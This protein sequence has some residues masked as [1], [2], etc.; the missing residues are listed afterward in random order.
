MWVRESRAVRSG[1]REGKAA[2]ADIQHHELGILLA[3]VYS[4][5]IVLLRRRREM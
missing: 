5:D 2:R 4:S 3:W 1:G